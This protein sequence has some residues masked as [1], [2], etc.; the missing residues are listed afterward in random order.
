[1][2][3]VTN[4]GAQ[5]ME[6]EPFMSGSDSAISSSSSSDSTTASEVRLNLP[7]DQGMVSGYNTGVGGSSG[8][9]GHGSGDTDQTYVITWTHQPSISW[10]L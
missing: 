6:R 5:G 3:Q 7:G 2:I 9:N 10:L 4:I 8:S 1:M